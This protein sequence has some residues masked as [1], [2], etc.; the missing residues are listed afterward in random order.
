MNCVLF[1]LDEIG[2]KHAPIHICI[3]VPQYGLYTYK[4]HSN[5]WL[6]LVLHYSLGPHYS[7]SLPYLLGMPYPLNP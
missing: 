6:T 7:L 3:L 1:P 4:L 2:G 5:L